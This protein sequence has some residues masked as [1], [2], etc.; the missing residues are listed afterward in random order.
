[1]RP[2][3]N[4]FRRHPKGT[5]LF[6]VFILYGWGFASTRPGD[7]STTEIVA[8]WDFGAKVDKEPDGWP[9]KWTRR[10]GRDF[11]K[12]IPIAIHQNAITPEAL[13][14]IENFRRFSSQCYLAWEQ[15]KWPWQVIPEKVPPA[16][17]Q[18][19]ERTVL[20]PYLREIGRAH[21]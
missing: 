10:T 16:I 14:D 19:L 21:V 11:P 15:K 4:A 6:L 9:D 12:F 18:F 8:E 3:L 2:L 20:N 17:D 7:N 1:M 5:A 13:N